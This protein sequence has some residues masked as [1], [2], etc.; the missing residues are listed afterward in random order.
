MLAKQ[1]VLRDVICESRHFN[2]EIVDFCKLK[3]VHLTFVDAYQELVA[4]LSVGKTHS[5]GVSYGFGLIFK[6][7]LIHRFEAGIWNVHPGILPENRGRHPL[8][9]SVL[10]NEAY[11]GVT[12]HV[13]DA[14]IDCGVHLAHAK[15]DRDLGDT[16]STAENKLIS[17][18]D[19]HLFADAVK[20]Y[21]DGK[22]T[23]LEQGIYNPSL[24]HRYEDVS[25]DEYSAI[26]LFNLT[27]SQAPYGGINISGKIYSECHIIYQ[28]HQAKYSDFDIYKT[29]DGELVAFK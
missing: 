25:P 3:G 21:E 23:R 26:F 2:F 10:K 20:N 28:T 29:K 12:I 16:P 8:S 5:L 27:K 6:E 24:A 9:W 11:F 18:L 14:E 22:G 15:I 7:D 1:G 13:M 4:L 19:D 17:V